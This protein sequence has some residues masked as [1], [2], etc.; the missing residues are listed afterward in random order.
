MVTHGCEAA[1]FS[2]MPL[3]TAHGREMTIQFRGN[4]FGG[5]FGHQRANCPRGVCYF[6]FCYATPVE[7]GEVLTN[8][9]LYGFMYTI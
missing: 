6:A 8:T 1:K 2:K 4:S 9:D 7:A 3:E 5:R